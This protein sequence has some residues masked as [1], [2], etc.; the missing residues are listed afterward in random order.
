MRIFGSGGIRRYGILW[1]TV[2]TEAIRKRMQ[3][4]S[5]VDFHYDEQRIQGQSADADLTG[6]L[7]STRK[8]GR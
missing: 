3:K 6:S 1:G 2:S 7:P 5:E 8:G 4:T